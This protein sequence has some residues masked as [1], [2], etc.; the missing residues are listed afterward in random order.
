MHVLN[1]ANWLEFVVIQ[2]TI[3]I[4]LHNRLSRSFLNFVLDHLMLIKSEYCKIQEYNMLSVSHH[5]R[6]SQCTVLLCCVA[7][8]RIK[9]LINTRA[10]DKQKG[11]E[12][13]LL[14]QATSFY[15]K[16]KTLMLSL[17]LFYSEFMI[18]LWLRLYSFTWETILLFIFLMKISERILLYSF[19]G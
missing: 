19:T 18:G 2:P 12:T 4:K 10:F 5:S 16:D 3:T 6:R 15:K 8:I 9:L 14:K 1:V 11:C 7:C 13:F 17:L